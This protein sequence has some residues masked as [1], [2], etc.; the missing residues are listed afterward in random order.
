MILH[1]AASGIPDLARHAASFPAVWITG[2]LQTL[3]AS[4][5]AFVLGT[6]LVIRLSSRLGMWVYALVAL[7]GTQAHELT[8]FLVAL[9][10]AARPSFP[11]LVPQRTAHGWRL[12]SV[13]FRAGIVRSVPIALAPLLL[14][15]LSLWWAASFLASAP[16]PQY[17]FH[18]WVVA[19]LLSASLPSS[20]DFRIAL[21][22][23]A[24]VGVIG[25]IIWIASL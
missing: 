18:A 3:S 10:L 11:S 13:A 22:A 12:G 21:P 23:L 2:E 1:S 15:P 17:A 14:A 9:I 7:P 6:L 5:L 8:H 20:A 19:A 16:W 24:I 25:M 4:D